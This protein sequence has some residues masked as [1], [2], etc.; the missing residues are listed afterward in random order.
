MPMWISTP[1]RMASVKFAPGPARDIQAARRG[2]RFDQEGSYGALA[3]PIIQPPV[4]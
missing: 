4:A 1:A 2:K 3:Q